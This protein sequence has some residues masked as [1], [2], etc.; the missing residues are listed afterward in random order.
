M[1]G[2]GWPNERDSVPGTEKRFFSSPQRPNGLWGP[3]SLLYNRNRV[4]FPL[5]KAAGA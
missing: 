5:A 3:T 1:L 2:A 4:L